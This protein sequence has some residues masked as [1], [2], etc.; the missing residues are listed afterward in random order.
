MHRITSGLLATAIVSLAGCASTY[1][2]S[3]LPEG[4]QCGDVSTIYELSN[5]GNTPRPVGR[6][7]AP[8]EPVQAAL[9]PRLATNDTYVL[10]T[11]GSHEVPIRTP[12]GVMRIW[13]APFEDTAGNLHLPGLIYTEIK[14]RQWLYGDQ[15]VSESTLSLSPLN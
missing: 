9:T 8:V 14:Q 6:D 3:G 2:C 1:S 5:D 10:P 11:L 4:V 15:N 13:L 7:S 12:S